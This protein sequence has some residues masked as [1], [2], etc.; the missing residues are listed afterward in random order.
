M[1][2]L[3]AL[4]AVTTLGLLLTGAISFFLQYER[5]LA[6]I[7][8]KLTEKV[9]SLP[10][11]ATATSVPAYLESVVTGFLPVPNEA[12]FGIVDGQAAVFPAAGTEFGE[13]DE[14]EIVSAALAQP[15]SDGHT[16]LGTVTTADAGTVRYIVQP[17][18]VPGDGRTGAYVRIVGLDAEL[19]PFRASVI[20]Y[21]IAGVAVLAAV[22]LMSW[23]LTGRLLAPLRRLQET[24]EAVTLGHFGD[25][26]E[27][28]GDDEIADFTRTVNSMFDRLEASVD[29]QRQLLDDVRHELKTPLTIMRGHLE[30]MNPRDPLDVEGVRQLG[31]SELDRMTQLVDD[32]D[33][34]ASAEDSDQFQRQDIDVF[35]LTLRVGGLVTAI[36]DHLWVVTDR[37][38]GVVVG[39]D[40]RLRQAWLQLADNAAKYAPAGST[41][42]IGS[43]VVDD[44]AR[45]WVRDHGPGIAPADRRR[46]F[47]RFD[48][49]QAGRGVNGSGLGLAIVDAIARAHGGSCVVTETPGGGATLTIE[50]PLHRSAPALPTPV[51]AEDVLHQRKASE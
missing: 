40:A 44:V 14:K 31:L 39:D 8:A 41:I 2:I 10:S 30:M 5:T 48:R 32:I 50:L 21:A 22:A 7:D 19:L 34:L 38:S 16:V 43:A 1:R 9:K 18:S 29:T 13:G 37:G 46:V 25:R 42:E 26:V 28:D 33:L 4:V 11:P 47:R 20:S 49:A 35:D 27:T 15:G 6:S 51:R 24:A 23:F 36:P 45:L 3:S 17:V 12:V